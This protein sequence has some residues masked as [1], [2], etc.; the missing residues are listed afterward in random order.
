MLQIVQVCWVAYISKLIEYFDTVIFVL[1]KKDSQISF[2]HVFHHTTVPVIAWLGV[3]Y[4]PGGY[5]TI[6]P[7]V[8]AFIHVWMYLY[9]GLASLGPE[10]QKYLGWKKY[11]TSLQLGIVDFTD[12]ELQQSDVVPTV[13]ERLA[14]EVLHLDTMMPELSNVPA[15]TPAETPRA[16]SIKRKRQQEDPRIEE[17]FIILKKVNKNMEDSS[18]EDLLDIYGHYVVSKMKKYSAQTQLVVEHEINKI[19]YQ[20]DMGCYDGPT[21]IIPSQ[22]EVH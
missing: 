1:R 22:N 18:K 11:L 19:L 4:G 14:D 20:A 8:N 13:E 15:S 17:A 16:S 7:M 5:N 2:L 12:V 9:Y 21:E 3:S 10:S 6:F